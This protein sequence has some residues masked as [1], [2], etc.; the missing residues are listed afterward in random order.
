MDLVNRLYFPIFLLCFAVPGSVSAQVSLCEPDETQI[1]TISLLHLNSKDALKIKDALTPFSVSSSASA[2]KLGYWAAKEAEEI[3]QQ[4]QAN[5]ESDYDALRNSAEFQSQEGIMAN[6]S[7]SAWH[8]H[9]LDIKEQR[10]EIAEA[11]LAYEGDSKSLLKAMRYAYLKAAVLPH[12]AI[13]GDPNSATVF[14]LTMSYFVGGKDIDEKAK[15]AVIEGRNVQAW[16]ASLERKLI[17]D[18]VK[19]L[20]LSHELK[21]AD[22]LLS[23]L[24]SQT[25][26]LSLLYGNVRIKSDLNLPLTELRSRGN[27]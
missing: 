6:F 22:A 8:L 12:P 5:L 16:I 20:T 15:N 9:D 23:S 2:I 24:H 14:P 17:P 19:N 1:N 11:Q 26:C 25:A 13:A 18:V 3:A 7:A 27:K 10:R 21:Q 4:R